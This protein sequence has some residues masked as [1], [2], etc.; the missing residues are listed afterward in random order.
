MTRTT[1]SS[2][3]AAAGTPQKHPSRLG[4]GLTD[5]APTSAPRTRTRRLSRSIAALSAAAGLV[6]GAAACSDGGS[7]DTPADKTTIKVVASTAIWGDVAKAVAKGHDNVEVVTILGPGVDD[8]HEYEATAKDLAQLKDADF[9]VANGG[10]YDSWLTDRVDSNVHVISALP[11][12]GEAA[13]HDHAA[14]GEG[15]STS[16]AP[17]G[18]ASS[19]AA[20]TA[21]SAAGSAASSAPASASKTTADEH[22]DHTHGAPAAGDHAGHDHGTGDVNPHAWFDMTAVEHFAQHLAAHLNEKDASI[23]KDAPEVTEKLHQFTERIKALPAK[24]VVTTEAIVE[25]ALK[26]SQLKDVTPAG[27]A[28]AVRKEGEPSAADVAATRQLIENGDVDVLI[29]NEQAQTPVA[30]QL[31]KAAKDKGVPIVNV[32]ETPDRDS[33]YFGYIDAFLNDLEKATNPEKATTR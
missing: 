23:P 30:Q 17:A 7:Q 29:T 28:A 16:A 19:A 8:P 14:H 32:N 33:D 2:N 5:A 1:M 21:G 10:G 24:K 25:D 31:T 13:G 6:L 22:A 3:H 9:V 27:F 18:G 20:T 12:S 4:A 11:V 15:E 26:S